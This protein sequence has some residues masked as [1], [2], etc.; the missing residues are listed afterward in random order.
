MTAQAL[1]LFRGHASAVICAL[2]SLWLCCCDLCFLLVLRVGRD[3]LGVDGLFHCRDY[4]VVVFI[5]HA[6][7]V[8]LELAVVSSHPLSW[9]SWCSN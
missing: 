3:L 9:Q 8:S 4:H 5:A 7:Q 1:P 6:L 2:C